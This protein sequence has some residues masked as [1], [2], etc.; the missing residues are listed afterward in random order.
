M[1]E[2]PQNQSNAW[3]YGV[4]VMLDALGGRTLNR[5][6]TDDFL[7]RRRKFIENL[8]NAFCEL[9]D[10]SRQHHI[11]EP[12]VFTFQDTI[13]ISWHFGELGFK[14]HPE[15]VLPELGLWLMQ[16]MKIGIEIGF[17]FRGAIAIG[18]YIKET[19]C[20]LGP[21]VSEAASWYERADWLGIIAAPSC[22]HHIYRIAELCRL[23][24][25][26]SYI[27]DR[28]I[29]YDVPLVNEGPMKL[30]AVSWPKA[31]C[32]PDYHGARGDFFCHLVELAVPVGTERKYA[33]TVNFFD[34][35]LGI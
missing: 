4:V 5:Q 13:I 27:G 1:E 31:Y 18:D 10:S 2:T 6:D 16:A 30:W 11:S 32:K 22:G 3:K 9:P 33:N 17:P 19:N 14:H 28:F 23:P 12:D 24:K 25:L 29:Q 7:D 35:C 20:L 34:H 8:K 26:D 21:A 15:V